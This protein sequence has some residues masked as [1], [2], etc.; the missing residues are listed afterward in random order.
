MLSNKEERRKQMNTKEKLNEMLKE[1]TGRNVL[2]SGGAYGRHWER[3]QERNFEEEPAVRLE[4]SEF[5]IEATHNL[6]HWLEE[7][8]EYDEEMTDKFLKFSMLPENEDKYWLENMEDF[9]QV[10]GDGDVVTVN[11][12]NGEDALS[13][14]I[15][16]TRF[17]LDGTGYVILQVHG[18]MD[19]R[20]GY[21]TPAI[22][23]EMDYW[24]LA[25]NARVSISCE[26]TDIDPNQLI[27]PGIE[28]NDYPHYW[29]TENGGYSWESEEDLDNLETYEITK[30]EE[31]KGKGKI[32]VDEDG[33]GYCPICGSRL[34]AY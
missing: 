25:D 34:V 4:F 27:L 20:G 17:E 1:N 28:R 11:T 13:Q 23:Q 6:Y 10:V 33:N 29:D 5:G 32:Y 19:V 8:L 31:E 16:Y 7:R 24:I 30:E 12:Y 18:G 21:S 2:D 14:T 22:F 15:Q 26:R 9:A 3:N